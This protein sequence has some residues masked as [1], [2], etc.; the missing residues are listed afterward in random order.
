MKLDRNPRP[1]ALMSAALRAVATD[2]LLNFS[3]RG[4]RNRRRTARAPR[5]PR[6]GCP[7]TTAPGAAGS[8]SC[9]PPAPS[10]PPTPSRTRPTS[11]GEPPLAAPPSGLRT[12]SPAAPHAMSGW[13][14]T[15]ASAAATSEK[16]SAR[17]CRTAAAFGGERSTVSTTARPLPAGSRRFSTSA[18]SRTAADPAR[19]HARRRVLAGQRKGSQHPLH[20]TG[21]NGAHVHGA[22]RGQHLGHHG[23]APV[24]QRLRLGA[25]PPGLRL[26]RQRQRPRLGLGERHRPHAARV[27]AG[28]RPARLS[29][30][31]RRAS[32][33]PTSSALPRPMSTRRP[34]TMSRWTH[35]RE[36]LARTRSMRPLPYT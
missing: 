19:H 20:V 28:A 34:C 7:W 25:A 3:P 33:R 35:E 26:L 6:P 15:L 23:R 29:V 4:T 2:V 1:V 17:W 24:A 31:M 21:R 22:Q 18:Q 36:P 10:T 5:P 27:A 30:A 11:L 14:S 9:A 32:A 16:C 8:A 12:G 13:P